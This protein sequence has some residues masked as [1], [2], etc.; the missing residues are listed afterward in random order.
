MCA[1]MVADIVLTG[2]EDNKVV[3]TGMNGAVLAEVSTNSAPLAICEPLDGS[4]SASSQLAIITEI[5]AFVGGIKELQGGFAAGV[6]KL[7]VGS[8]SDKL[9]AAFW[10]VTAANSGNLTSV[11]IFQLVHGNPP[12]RC[13]LY[14]SDTVTLVADCSPM[15]VRG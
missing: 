9:L 3:L 7:D 11:S 2:G 8:E 6:Q 4:T 5:S 13:P 14:V 10:C 15:Q 12:R 1:A